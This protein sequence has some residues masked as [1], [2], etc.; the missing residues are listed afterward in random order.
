MRDEFLIV[1]SEEN[2]SDLIKY[3]FDTNK[4]RVISNRIMFPDHSTLNNQ[5]Y[6]FSK[7]NRK[8]INCLFIG[9]IAT[10]YNAIMKTIDL[11]SLAHEK[12]FQIQLRILGDG[13]GIINVQEKANKL[14]T[15]YD[16]MLVHIEG[17]CKNVNDYIDDAH[18]VFG[19]GRS[20]IDSIA[21]LR[22]SIVASENGNFFITTPD[23]IERLSYY[24]FSGRNPDAGESDEKLLSFFEDIISGNYDT[25]ILNQCRILAEES[26]NIRF[27]EKKIVPIYDDLLHDFKKRNFAHRIF[28]STKHLIC[29]YWFYLK[30]HALRIFKVE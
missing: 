27:L 3:G 28:S 8:V 14:N 23:N 15:K 1:Y 16:K 5:P 18:V 20:I 22:C 11:I 19:K 25:S 10:N 12:G 9:R 13:E 4:I 17:Y 2:K 21:R 26:Y 29:L 24:N 6:M 30:Y 7:S